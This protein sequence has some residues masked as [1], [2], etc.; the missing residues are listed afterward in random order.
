MSWVTVYFSWLLQWSDVDTSLP[1]YHLHAANGNQQALQSVKHWEH[2]AMKQYHHSAS[3]V[4]EAAG[5]LSAE[6]TPLRFSHNCYSLPSAR[7]ER[8][9]ISVNPFVG[10]CDGPSDKQCPARMMR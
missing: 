10:C 1:G 2:I 7:F 5:S 9:S 3:V 8:R 6:A 4:P